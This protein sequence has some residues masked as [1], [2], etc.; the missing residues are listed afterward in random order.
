MYYSPNKSAKNLVCLISVLL[1]VIAIAFFNYLITNTSCATTNTELP[2]KVIFLVTVFFGGFG[3]I[4]QAVNS[5]AQ[6][7]K[8][9]KGELNISFFYRRT[10]DILGA[11]CLGIGGALAINYFLVAINK[12]DI[13]NNPKNIMCLIGLNTVAGYLGRRALAGIAGKVE[14]ELQAFKTKTIEVEGEIKKEV[15]L[16]NALE[17]SYIALN[18]GIYTDVKDAIKNLVSFREQF[19]THR[20]LAIILGRLYKKLE[21][22]D[23]AI[24]VLTVFL[25]N[26][27]KKNEIDIDYAAALYN[28]ACY[29]TLAYAEAAKIKRPSVSHYQLK[30][31][32]LEDLRKTVGLNPD[33][34][35]DAAEDKDFDSIRDDVEFKKIIQ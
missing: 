4:L 19:P 12:L 35:K 6:D 5:L 28:R 22:F 8:T 16:S 1:I 3:G 30:T 33:H 14:R 10:F 29:N 2:L 24:N 11:V 9:E 26:K 18:T 13:T 20:K 27:E 15:S 34:K 31:N 23:D 17:N 21:E 25:R 32:A 7:I